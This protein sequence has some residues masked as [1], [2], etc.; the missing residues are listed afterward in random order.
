MM[1]L[2]AIIYLKITMRQLLPV[3]KTSF[4]SASQTPTYFNIVVSFSL[5]KSRKDLSIDTKTRN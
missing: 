5:S 4:E 1:G 2:S 3:Q